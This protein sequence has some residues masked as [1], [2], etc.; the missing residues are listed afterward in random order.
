MKKF[1]TTVGA[2]A[3]LAGTLGVASSASAAVFATIS[4]T[5]IK[6]QEANGVNMLPYSML[7]GLGKSTLDFVPSGPGPFEVEFMFTPGTGDVSGQL[8]T[9]TTVGSTVT[10]TQGG[11]QGGFEAIYFGK[12]KPI[13][14]NGVTLTRGVTDIFDGTFT[15]GTITAQTVAGVAKPGHLTGLVSGFSSPLVTLPSNGSFNL[16]LTLRGMGSNWIIKGNNQPLGT[17][18]ANGNGVFGTV[19]EPASWALMLLGVGGIGAMARR[20]RTAAVAA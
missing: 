2:V 15:G 4:G 20:R 8:A 1:M 12:G 6:W 5:H 18:N 19:P 14:V 16:S 9:S 13:V 17:F 11:I 7:Y 3:L 10:Y